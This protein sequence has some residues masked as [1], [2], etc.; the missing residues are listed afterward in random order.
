MREKVVDKNRI[1]AVVSTDKQGGQVKWQDLK[2]RIDF[3]AC[4]PAFFFLKT[5]DPGFKAYIYPFETVSCL[6]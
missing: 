1:R 4:D 6:P 2:T 3:W 5:A